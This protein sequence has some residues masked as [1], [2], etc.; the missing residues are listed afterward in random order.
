MDHSLFGI[1]YLDHEVALVRLRKVPVAQENHQRDV[2]TP[3][4]SAHFSQLTQL[5]AAAWGQLQTVG[6]PSARHTLEETQDLVALGVLP[7]S[8]DAIERGYC[9]AGQAADCPRRSLGPACRDSDDQVLPHRSEGGT[10]SY[11]VDSDPLTLRASAITTQLALQ[12]RAPASI[13]PE[14]CARGFRF[15]SLAP[16]PRSPAND[17]AE[18][19]DR[20]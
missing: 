13:E 14:W 8:P 3:A 9:H 15:L 19:A 5:I 16:A 12:T 7:I 17:S 6:D 20:T 4:H 1:K 11:G 2:D 10:R 18:L